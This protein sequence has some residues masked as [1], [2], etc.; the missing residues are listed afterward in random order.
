M[1]RILIEYRFVIRVALVA[2]VGGIGL[3]AWPLPIDHPILGL[4]AL[5]RPTIYQGLSY[6]YAAM[7]FRR[8]SS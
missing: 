5:N 8:R 4:I 1:R 7:W 6:T 3:Y 2:I